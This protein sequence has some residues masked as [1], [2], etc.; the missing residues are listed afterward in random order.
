MA[1]ILNQ[2]EIT[3]S[4][5]F[6]KIKNG[7][8]FYNIPRNCVTITKIDAMNVRLHILGSNS[9]VPINVAEVVTPSVVD[10]DALIAALAT[11]IFQDMTGGVGSATY[12]SSNLIGGSQ[13]VATLT[14]RNAIPTGQ[15]RFGMI[16]TVNSDVTGTNNQTYI[17]ANTIL[18]GQNDTITDNNNWVPFNPGH[19]WGKSATVYLMNSA[20]DALAM[21]G[22]PARCYSTFQTAYNAANT[23]QVALGGSNVVTLLVGPTTA[24]SVG[25]LT[26][27]AAFNRNIRIVG[28]SNA[29]SNLGNIVATN[30]AGAGFSVGTAAAL[31]VFISEC[32]VGNITTSATGAAVAAG[33]AVSLY[34]SN[35]VVGIITTG[36]TNASNTG[37]SGLV[38]ISTNS[39]MRCVTGNIVTTA[40]GT[41]AAGAV[42]INAS[43]AVIGNITTAQGTNSGGQ[44]SIQNADTVGIISCVSTSGAAHQIT[45]IRTMT[46]LTVTAPSGSVTITNVISTGVFTITSSSAAPIVRMTNSVAATYTSNVGASSQLYQC[47]FT[48]AVNT[49]GTGSM[50]VDCVC[51]GVGAVNVSLATA[52]TTITIARTYISG[53]LTCN[54]VSPTLT[55][56]NVAASVVTMFASATCKDVNV[57]GTWGVNGGT[58]GT[59]MNCNAGTFANTGATGLKLLGCAFNNITSTT[60]LSYNNSALGTGTYPLVNSTRM[61]NVHENKLTMANTQATGT[62]YTSLFSSS[63]FKSQ[64][65]V[66]ASGILIPANSVVQYSQFAVRIRGMYF[67]GATPG[68]FTIRIGLNDAQVSIGSTQTLD[69]N[70]S[71]CPFDIDV[72]LNFIS[73]GSSGYTTYSGILS[74]GKM[75]GSQ[76]VTSLSS[77]KSGFP[78]TMPTNTTIDNYIT[79]KAAFSDPSVDNFIFVQNVS[80]DLI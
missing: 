72:V 30:A 36:A 80:V 4:G 71:D 40:Q 73:L 75:N 8:T 46:N 43:L 76:Q 52:A 14:A 26:L 18:G 74:Y 51:R 42:Q 2:W 1:S 12:D 54:S 63:S 53:S 7:T 58:N 24:A 56:V 10:S 55:A 29:V 47:L 19:G 17:L 70:T 20:A 45:N 49:L 79:A 57:D 65:A 32:T 33:G 5:N 22:I 41:G 27:T 13:Q 50:M 15:R 11:V 67:T 60:I 23:L 28:V 61:S 62:S 3:S 38:A 9:V 35:A 21:G 59:L 6:V 69:V 64:Y 48:T 34:L 78:Y 68:T 77:G 25:D 37:T 44:I 16:V 39:V 31:G 66:S